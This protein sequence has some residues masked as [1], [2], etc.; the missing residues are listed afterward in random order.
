[1][2]KR[3]CRGE[4]GCAGGDGDVAPLHGPPFGG[5]KR[6][7]QVLRR[8]FVILR[9]AAAELEQFERESDALWAR[10]EALRGTVRTF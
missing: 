9:L 8:R 1:M 5:Q 6:A 7:S 4:D 2:S 10:L 3:A